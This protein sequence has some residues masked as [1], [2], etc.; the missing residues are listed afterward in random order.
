VVPYSTY[1]AGA[2]WLVEGETVASF[3]VMDSQDY[4]R[5]PGT[6]CF[7]TLETRDNRDSVR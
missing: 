3:A 6:F 5:R 7:S 2:A 1:A 4:S